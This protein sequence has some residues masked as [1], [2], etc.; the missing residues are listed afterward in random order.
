M[1]VSLVAEENPLLHGDAAV[2]RML[3]FGHGAA[4]QISYG[5]VKKKKNAIGIVILQIYMYF[6]RKIKHLFWLE[7]KNTFL[8]DLYNA[9]IKIH[10]FLLLALFTRDDGVKESLWA[11]E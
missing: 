3:H 8:H 7:K 2:W 11:L 5:K 4:K 9:D 1:K 10:I 6:F